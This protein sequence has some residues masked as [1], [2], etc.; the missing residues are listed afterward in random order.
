MY[1]SSPKWLTIDT[2]KSSSNYV[3]VGNVQTTQGTHK[4]T[5][6]GHNKPE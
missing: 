4:L 5:P 3:T 2:G 1:S 6:K